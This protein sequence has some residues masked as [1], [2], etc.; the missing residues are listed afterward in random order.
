[1]PILNGVWLLQDELSEHFRN[2]PDGQ[3]KEAQTSEELSRE[4]IEMVGSNAKR[5][6]NQVRDMADCVKGLSTPVKCAPCRI[7]EIVDT[8]FKT[9]RFSASQKGI[10]LISQD[11]DTLPTIQADDGRLFKAFYNLVNNALAEVPLGGTITITGQPDPDKRHIL[12]QVKDTGAGMPQEIRESLF[13]SHVVSRKVGGTGLGT[14]IIKDAIDSHGG[15]IT[16]ES[17]LGAGT[18]FHIRLPFDGGTPAS[19]ST[20]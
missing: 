19:T 1:M 3:A 17:E 15:S 11:L 12:V 10:H 14:K 7:S 5:I 16:V 20:E 9:L 6:E 18:T 8:V 13:T 4:I 2:L